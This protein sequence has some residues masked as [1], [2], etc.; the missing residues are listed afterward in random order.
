VGRE[1]VDLAERLGDRRRIYEAC[2]VAISSMNAHTGFVLIESPELRPWIERMDR[3][4]QPGS[5]ERIQTDCVHAATLRAEGNEVGAREL[6]ARALHLAR[7]LG[8]MR[9]YPLLPIES[10]NV[11]PAA[12]QQ[13]LEVA[14][15]LFATLDESIARRRCLGHFHLGDVYLTWGDRSKAEALWAKIPGIVEQSRLPWL[16]LVA[17]RAR[18]LLEC[19]D[20]ELERGAA[21]ANELKEEAEALG[22]GPF[23]RLTASIHLR[24]TH[25]Y[26]GQWIRP[27][28]DFRLN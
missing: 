22:A 13:R 20:G 10:W 6:E 12:Q 16:A 15:E 17:H 9:I 4:T 5:W 3:A 26:L 14:N 21:S 18:L 19:L 23:G 1:A 25:L 11:A 7:E 2:L 8:A 24:R 27:W 28:T